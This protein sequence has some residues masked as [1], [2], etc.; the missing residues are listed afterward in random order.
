MEGNNISLE[1]EK[2]E[3]LLQELGKKI[4]GSEGTD[5]EKSSGKV[6]VR[7]NRRDC[8]RQAKRTGL[9]GLRLEGQTHRVSKLSPATY[10]YALKMLPNI[11]NLDPNIKNVQY[12]T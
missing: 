1:G 7:E 12:L 11:K 8:S 9:P 2:K 5:A 10:L 3:S 4:K 6:Q